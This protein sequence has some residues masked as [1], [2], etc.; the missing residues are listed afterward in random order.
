MLK[1]IRALWVEAARRFPVSRLN[2]LQ[3]GRF[4]E[5][6]KFDPSSF[7]SPAIAD[8]RKRVGGYAGLATCCEQLSEEKIAAC[9][10]SD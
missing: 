1:R 4:E 2:H 3:A 6:A 5:H 8:E 9:A 7:T 10:N